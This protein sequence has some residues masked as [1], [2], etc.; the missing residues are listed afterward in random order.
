MKL[1]DLY[2]RDLSKVERITGGILLL[3]MIIAISPIGYIEKLYYTYAVNFGYTNF[4][5]IFLGLI[6]LITRISIIFGICALISGFLSKITSYSKTV[7][8][9]KIVTFTLQ[10][11]GIILA[12]ILFFT[13]FQNVFYASLHHVHVKT[14]TTWNTFN[15]IRAWINLSA[16]ITYII[17]III[18]VYLFIQEKIQKKKK[19]N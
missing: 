15:Q 5:V 17:V 16:I 18:N 2:K 12:I 3:S 1:K 6:Y 11:I 4:I 10:I 8:M 19:K 13:H 14:I 9:L 7:N